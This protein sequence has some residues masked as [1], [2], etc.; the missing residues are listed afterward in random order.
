M[1][2]NQKLW[3]FLLKQVRNNI[4]QRGKVEKKMLKGSSS[5]MYGQMCLGHSIQIGSCYLLG[6]RAL[7][8]P[9][10]YHQV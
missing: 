4:R 10:G 7:E 8:I 6:T 5:V 2:T 3:T 9:T 1:A